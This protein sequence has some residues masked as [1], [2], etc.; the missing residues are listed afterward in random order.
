MGISAQ[1]AGE[2]MR[3]LLEEWEAEEEATDEG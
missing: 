3:K 1:D 2:L